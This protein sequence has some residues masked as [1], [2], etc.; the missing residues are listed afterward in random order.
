MPSY[1][2]YN[3]DTQ[4]EWTEVMSISDMEAFLEKNPD[5]D[6]RPALVFLG[7]P[8][9]QGLKKPSDGFRDILRNIKKQHGGKRGAKATGVNTF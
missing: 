3:K 2:F 9:R 8:V 4:V 5:V 7:D 6:T 1:T